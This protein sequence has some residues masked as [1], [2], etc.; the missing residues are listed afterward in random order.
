MVESQQCHTECNNVACGHMYCTPTQAIHQCIAEEGVS[1]IDRSAAPGGSGGA[2]V[3]LSLRV[4]DSVTLQV[5]TTLGQTVW[6]ATF[7]YIAYW[8]DA[9]LLSSPCA[10]VLPQIFGISLVEA[11]S[12][13]TLVRKL[14]DRGFFW[15]PTLLVDN[16]WT[17]SV[18]KSASL[19][20]YPQTKTADGQTCP[21]CIA[22]REV[23][24][25]RVKQS[26]Y[27][28]R[29]PFDQQTITLRLQ[30]PGANL[31]NCPSI[32]ETYPS[33]EAAKTALLPPTQE[34]FGIAISLNEAVEADRDGMGE[35][36][37][38]TVDVC[39]LTLPVW[40]PAFR[41]KPGISCAHT[42]THTEGWACGYRAHTTRR[43]TPAGM[44]FPFFFVRLALPSSG[45]TA[46]QCA[47]LHSEG[48]PD[49][50]PHRASCASR[51]VADTP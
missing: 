45:G 51:A 13:Q 24:E 40:T 16:E 29:Y 50:L 34:W 15:L 19:L 48:P 21:D 38:C 46:A 11:K 4:R 5:D 12:Q 47:D 49:R 22:Y 39:S 9:R 2:E 18:L 7:E 41:F 23:R 36:S 26:F 14:A 37:T 25:V 17:D 10:A 44:M 27:F 8:R 30:L 20:S 43:T 3:R 35:V 6:S 33:V 42:Q 32:L 1:R 28:D 31:T